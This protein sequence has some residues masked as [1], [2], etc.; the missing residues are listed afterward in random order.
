MVRI[1][2]RIPTHSTAVYRLLCKRMCKHFGISPKLYSKNS[3]LEE[4]LILDEELMPFIKK[5]FDSYK[6]N[7]AFFRPKEY[8][9]IFDSFF[10]RLLS[11]F[12][13]K[14]KPIFIR[15]IVNALSTKKWNDAGT[16]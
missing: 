6:V 1:H 8:F 7:Y 2:K 4:F 16:Q 12:V 14:K 13:N 11:M 5:L 10:E 9:N 3:S 15:D